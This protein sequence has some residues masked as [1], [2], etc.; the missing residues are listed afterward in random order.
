MYNL[1]NY[2]KDLINPEK[3]QKLQ[4]FMDNPLT[5][6][7]EVEKRSRVATDICSWVRAMY[8]YYWVYKEVKPKR[9]EVEKMQ[10]QLDV[11][12]A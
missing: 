12:N 2:E 4:K 3:I 8:N 9:L 5:N 7:E 11:A 10:K 6:P 1:R